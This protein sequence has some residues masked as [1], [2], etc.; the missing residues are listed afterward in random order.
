MKRLIKDLV[1]RAIVTSRL[2]ALLLRNTAVVVAFHRVQDGPADSSGLTIG[3][4]LFERYCRFFRRHF[5]V[6]PL[7]AVVDRQEMTDAPTP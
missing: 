6:T 3:V 2:S 1:G 4:D 7:R 5:R